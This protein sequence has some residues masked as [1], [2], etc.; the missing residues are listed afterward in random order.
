MVGRGTRLAQNKKDLLLLD[1]LWHTERHD[2]C[3]PASLICTSENVA[4]KM[5]TNMMEQSGQMF[6]IEE[7]EKQAKMDVQAEREEALASQLKE[8]RMRKRK[9]VDPIQFEMSIQAEDLSSYEPGFGW[10]CAPASPKQLKALEAFGIFPDQI[11]NAG[12]ASLLLDRLNKRSLEGLSTP[13][14]IRF[15]ES[16]GFLHVGQWTFN[17]ASN[18]IQRF[19]TNGWRTPIGIDTNTYVP[20]SMRLAK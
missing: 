11:Q 6:D 15:L 2:L 9:L 8:M 12:Y 10:E 17:D 5:T 4:R 1:F 18:M 14:Q 3:H 13:K 16:K 19:A 7:A 20:E